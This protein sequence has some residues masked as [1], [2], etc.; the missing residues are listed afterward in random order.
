MRVDWALL[1]ERFHVPRE[2][3]HQPPRA[4][5][6]VLHWPWVWGLPPS[7]LTLR[8]TSCSLLPSKDDSGINSFIPSWTHH[9]TKRATQYVTLVFTVCKSVMLSPW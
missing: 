7:A 5:L 4:E 8:S 2:A 3:L 6:R 1:G 9:F